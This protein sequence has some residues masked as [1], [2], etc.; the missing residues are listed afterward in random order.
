M[1]LDM[2]LAS[3]QLHTKWHLDPYSHLA[4]TDIGRILGGAVPLWG[5]GAGSPSNAMWP[6]RRPTPYL[7]AKFHLNPANHNV[8]KRTL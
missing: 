8:A 7:R 2:E 5:R 6:G 3:A 4:A 1:P